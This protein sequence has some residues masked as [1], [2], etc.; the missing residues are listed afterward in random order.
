[1]PNPP[2]GAVALGIMARGDGSA[3]GVDDEDMWDAQRLLAEEEGIFCEP[4]AA[5][6]LAGLIKQCREQGGMASER[7][8]C[9]VSGWS[10]RPRP[11]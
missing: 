11:S 10:R 4:A 8:V 7:V 6:P 5:A 2:D 1:M 3:L 9:V